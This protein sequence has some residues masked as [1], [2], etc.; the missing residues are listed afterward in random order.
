MCSRNSTSH[1]KPSV[2]LKAT[3]YVNTRAE[4]ETQTYKHNCAH[5]LSLSFF[6]CLSL[7]H[8]H[9]HTQTCTLKHARTHTHTHAH[10]HTHSPYSDMYNLLFHHSYIQAYMHTHCH[11][12]TRNSMYQNIHTV[13]PQ[14]DHYLIPLRGR[15]I[16]R[17]TNVCVSGFNSLN[18]DGS[19]RTSNGT[20]HSGGSPLP[21]AYLGLMHP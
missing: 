12:H 1:Q 10:T 16:S 6:L 4:M 15:D 21:R 11:T 17:H 5:S 8:T 14:T 2:Q 7:H 18:F 19:A 13:Y 9:T 20:E 3:A